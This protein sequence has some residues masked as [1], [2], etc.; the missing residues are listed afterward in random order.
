MSL[1][2]QML[3]DLDKRGVAIRADG[4]SVRPVYDRKR[5]S[6]VVL[7]ALIVL[8]LAGMAGLWAGLRDKSPPLSDLPVVPDEAVRPPAVATVPSPPPRARAKPAQTR[9][10]SDDK[11]QRVEKQVIALPNPGKSVLPAPPSSLPAGRVKTPF[12]QALAQAKSSM[13]TTTTVEVTDKT[14][15]QTMTAA[16]GAVSAK[17]PVPA[18]TVTIQPEVTAPGIDKQVRQVTVEQQAENE[19]RKANGLMQQGRSDEAIAGYRSALKLEV[20]HVAARQA[21]VGLLLESKR[22]S[23]AEQAL[24]EGLDY[25]PRQSNFAMLLARLQVD[26][27]ALQQALETLRVSLPYAEQRADYQ[28]FIA[29]VLQRLGRHKEAIEHYQSALRLSPNSGVW[30][31][32]LGISLQAEKRDEDARTAFRQAADS[33]TLSKELQAFVTKRLRELTP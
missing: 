33:H 10:G 19:F 24:Q 25:N 31:M 8:L 27:N 16:T 4:E 32:G 29:A 14:D 22:N 11:Q 7:P 21:M 23:D 26:R 12:E 9:L 13:A 15:R 17:L 3:T 6:K 28:A 20:G 2:N 18:K 1:I 5:R 30:L